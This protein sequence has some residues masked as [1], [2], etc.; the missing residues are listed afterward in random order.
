[1]LIG[2]LARQRDVNPITSVFLSNR[3]YE[4]YA[5]LPFK[6]FGFVA[7]L[8]LFLMAIT[9][10]DFWLH[11]LE[12]RVWQ[13]VHMMVYF[14]YSLTILHVALGILPFETSAMSGGLVL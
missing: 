6:A 10:H 9:T 4:L 5:R 13:V 1:L 14:G 8:I 12:P 3:R 2:P 7:L 11:N